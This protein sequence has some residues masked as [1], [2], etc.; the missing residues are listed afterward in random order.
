MQPLRINFTLE[1]PMRVPEYPIHLDALLAWASVHL[2]DQAGSAEPYAA[3][4][5]L[6]LQEHGE[7]DDRVWCASQLL[8]VPLA[9]PEQWVM[10][11]R[12]ESDS[13]AARKGTVFTD[14][15]NKLTQGTG[16]FKSFMWSES[17]QWV[18]TVTAYAV[19]DPAKIESLLAEVKSI[20]KLRRHYMGAIVSRAITEDARAYEAWKLRV[21]PTHEPGYEPV[22]ATT[23]PPY[24]DRTKQRIAY[25]PLTIPEDVHAQP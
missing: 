16:P 25:R 13:L 21:M 5:D 7:G 4:D 17:V 23:R 20:G 18:E 9:P 11:K 1:R 3:Q 12:F 10:T 14:G 19:G 6:P 2:A 15:P 8:F 22:Q 24:W